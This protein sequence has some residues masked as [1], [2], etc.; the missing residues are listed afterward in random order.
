MQLRLVQALGESKGNTLILGMPST[1]TVV[2]VPRELK[3]KPSEEP[4]QEN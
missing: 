4:P 3:D 2:P 1:A